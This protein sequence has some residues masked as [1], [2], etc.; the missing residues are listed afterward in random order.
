MASEK[1]TVEEACLDD[2]LQTIA[3]RVA[4]SP[5]DPS[6]VLFPKPSRAE[7]DPESPK[8]NSTEWARAFYDLRKQQVSG[9]E[10]NTTGV[11]FRDLHAYGF[12]GGTDIQSTVASIFLKMGGLVKRMVNPLESQKIQI[13][14]GLEG[15][16]HPGETVAVLGP[17]GSGCSTFLKTMSGNTDGFHISA[18]SVINYQGIRP[19]QMKSAFR[20]EAIYVSEVDEHFPHLTVGDTLYFAAR[21]RT[22]AN[23]PDNISRQSYAEHLRDVTMN[24]FGISNV[25]NTRVGDSV[26]RGVSGGERKRVSV[27]EAAL[28]YA[29]LQCW[30]NST[31]GLDSANAV[32]FCK[33]LRTQADILGITS[34]VSIYQA[35]QDAY[36]ASQ[37]PLTLRW[38]R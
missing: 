38:K 13:L 33:A 31:R 28:S 27:A 29:P 6:H 24:I 18:E 9:A 2:S 15:V 1:E 12:G 7:L 23:I 36:D 21:A 35:P 32:N 19:E 14:Q 5:H 3:K 11:A 17:P 22:P 37:T 30:D 16:V 4:S 10:P 8:F 26:I 20:G 34:F 25:K